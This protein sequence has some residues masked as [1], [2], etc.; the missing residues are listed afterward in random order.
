[1]A[2]LHDD[3]RPRLERDILTVAELVKIGMTMAR[4]LRQRMEE[5]DRDAMAKYPRVAGAVVRAIALHNVLRSQL[6]G[7]APT[8]S[9]KPPVSAPDESKSAQRRKQQVKSLVEGAI[10]ADAG[11]RRTIEHRLLKMDEWLENPD[12]AV[13]LAQRTSGEI[14]AD[15]CRLLGI[16]PDI[17]LWPQ[18]A[19]WEE[20]IR[21]A[22][23]R[24]RH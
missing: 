3:P 4:I 15:M 6:G 18:D 9:S 8:L 10:K 16:T 11:G 23:A 20:A 7:V 12:L 1:M 2:L 21:E 22:K 5:G 14:A 17:S 19:L 13:D 24:E